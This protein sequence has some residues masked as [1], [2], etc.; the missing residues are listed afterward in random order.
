MLRHRHESKVPRGIVEL[1]PVY[2]MNN[3]FTAPFHFSPDEFF[4]DINVLG[5]FTSVDRNHPISLSAYPKSTFP[6]MTILALMKCSPAFLRTKMPLAL[7]MST[8]SPHI[9]F[10]ANWAFKIYTAMAAFVSAFSRAIA[11]WAPMIPSTEKY[12][13]AVRTEAGINGSSSKF[14]KMAHER[15]DCHT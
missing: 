14:R 7:S 3:F 9:G 2:M 15:S 8:A 5:H 4:H 6:G 1:I 10:F 13:F 11:G 12:F